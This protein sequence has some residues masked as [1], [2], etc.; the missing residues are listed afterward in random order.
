MGARRCNV[1]AEFVGAE[2]PR[3][4][5]LHSIPVAIGEVEHVGGMLKSDDSARIWGD[6]SICVAKSIELQPPPRPSLSIISHGRRR[7]TAQQRWMRRS[8]G[9]RTSWRNFYESLEI[10]RSH[11]HGELDIWSACIT[12]PNLPRRRGIISNYN[13]LNWPQRRMFMIQDRDQG[14]LA[15]NSR[16]QRDIAGEVDA[17][18]VGKIDEINVF[19]TNTSQ[20][21]VVGVKVVVCVDPV[22]KPHSPVVT[23]KPTSL[24][25]HWEP[26]EVFAWGSS[27]PTLP[28]T[29]TVVEG[30]GARSL[31]CILVFEKMPKGVIDAKEKGSVSLA[32]QFVAMENSKSGT[33]HILWVFEKMLDGLVIEGS[34]FGIDHISWVLEKRPKQG[35]K[36]PDAALGDTWASMGRWLRQM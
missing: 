8:D 1:L 31:S 36:E 28:S 10:R 32:R 7:A 5:G 27:K 22:Q 33:N 26:E 29:A 15:D 9:G 21:V 17:G 24:S 11:R 23:F 20:G 25:S 3:R 19:S 13:S 14:H 34:N 6:Q 12:D 30:M 35:S 2:S 4:I 18:E 16:S